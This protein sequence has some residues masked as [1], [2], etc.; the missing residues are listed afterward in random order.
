M[1]A[2]ER[3]KQGLGR[4]KRNRRRE[5]VAVGME[6]LDTGI[7][8]ISEIWEVIG[9]KRRVECGVLFL[10]S[11]KY[12]FAITGSRFVFPAGLKSKIFQGRDV[13]THQPSLKTLFREFDRV[14][15]KRM[16][17]WSDTMENANVATSL[18]RLRLFANL[19]HAQCLVLTKCFPILLAQNPLIDQFCAVQK[20]W[21]KY[22]QDFVLQ[23]N[24]HTFR[25]VL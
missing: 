23:H 15:L 10:S 18:N 25:N 22:F 17:G 4:R 5:I 9:N 24:V 12:H 8:K 2:T 13:Y 6:T 19:N 21:S 20:S 3:R 7:Q 11:R 14:V 1:P 16:C